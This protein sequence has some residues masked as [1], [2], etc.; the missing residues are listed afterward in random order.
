MVIVAEV[1]VV[2]EVT[3]VGP[4][5]K[6]MVILVAA[7]L[8]ALAPISAKALAAEVVSAWDPVW[9]STVIGLPRE[10]ATFLELVE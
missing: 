3:K 1:A 2:S 5:I 6:S 10:D 8:T 7:S 4:D 9:K